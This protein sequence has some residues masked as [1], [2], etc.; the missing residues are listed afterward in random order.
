MRQRQ[1]DLQILDRTRDW[2]HNL[3]G[4]YLDEIS[5]LNI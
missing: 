3:S 2:D 5:Y 1:G 4:Y